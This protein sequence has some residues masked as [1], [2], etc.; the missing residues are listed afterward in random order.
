MELFPLN[1]ASSLSLNSNIRVHAAFNTINEDSDMMS[2]LISQ[3][4]QTLNRESQLLKFLK[5]NRQN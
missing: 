5:N 2:N 1:F 3:D 4:N